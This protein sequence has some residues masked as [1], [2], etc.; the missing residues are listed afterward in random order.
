M[1]GRIRAALVIATVATGATG[2]TSIGLP[3]TALA[4]DAPSEELRMEAVTNIVGFSLA[5]DPRVLN[6]STP[7]VELRG[8]AFLEPGNDWLAADSG[9]ALLILPEKVIEARI[10]A[11]LYPWRLTAVGSFL[12]SLYLR[13]GIHGLA[14]IDGFDAGP[15]IEFGI[16]PGTRRVSILA[17]IAVAGYL[18]NPRLTV[19]FRFG[20]GLRF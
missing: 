19:E 6:L 17:G 1:I 11:R 2:A 15:D 4:D 13:P 16:A 14:V 7:M 8:V 18:V 3:R 12:R 10:G 9:F 20:V 5:K